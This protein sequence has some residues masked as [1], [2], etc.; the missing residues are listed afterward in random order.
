[1][2]FLVRFK[3]L[4]RTLNMKILKQCGKN[5]TSSLRIAFFIRSAFLNAFALK[6]L[7]KI[8]QKKYIAKGSIDLFKCQVKTVYQI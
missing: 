4:K 1:M 5:I 8:I 7:K 3:T 6:A 2:K